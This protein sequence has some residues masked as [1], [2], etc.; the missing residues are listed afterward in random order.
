MSVI[1]IDR[2]MAAAGD[3]QPNPDA[4]RVSFADFWK[5]YPRRVARKDAERAW[6]KVDAGC[7]SSLMAALQSQKKSDDWRKDG[8]RFI[9]YPG[10]WLRG[11]RW[12]DELDTDLGMGQCSWNMHGN[13]GMG[14]RCEQPATT[15]K[16]G[17][18][19]CKRH[20]EQVN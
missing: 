15:E 8:G 4:P 1:A 10:S 5:A 13:R 11:E 18:A 14:G 16:R 20:G 17:V 3:E 7:H 2:K 9:P 19:Y 6:M 12:T